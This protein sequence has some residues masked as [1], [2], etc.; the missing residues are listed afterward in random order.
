MFQRDQEARRLARRRRGPSR[1]CASAHHQ[2]GCP[3]VVSVFGG[4]GGFAAE[5]RAF[6]TSASRSGRNSLMRPSTKSYDFV[7]PLRSN[8]FARFKRSLPH[9]PAAASTIVCAGSLDVPASTTVAAF[10]QSTN[11]LISRSGKM[12]GAGC[13]SSGVQ[14]RPQRRRDHG[15]DRRQTACGSSPI[16]HW[17]H[18]QGR[19]RG[20]LGGTVGVSPTGVGVGHEHEPASLTVISEGKISR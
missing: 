17:R 4:S 20:D 12:G 9:S 1:P 6:R 8:A 3:F 19:Q 11:F 7:T 13:V 15:E 18:L 14:A 10:T 16:R 5:A 2:S